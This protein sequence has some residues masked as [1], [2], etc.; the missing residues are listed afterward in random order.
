M[1]RISFIF[2]EV[3]TITALLV[4][5]LSYL[6]LII[7]DWPYPDETF[8]YSLVKEHGPLGAIYANWCCV[9]LGRTTG[10]AWIDIWM[11]I[12]QILSV[13]SILVFVFYKL[14]TFVAIIFSIFYTL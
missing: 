14:I 4:L 11:W 8:Q 13:N 9:S 7:I 3:I 10:V 12:F 2:F 6:S 5:I 1:K